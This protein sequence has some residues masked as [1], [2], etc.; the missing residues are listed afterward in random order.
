MKETSKYKHGFKVPDHYFDQL[1]KTIFDRLQE[2]G[3]PKST[4][5]IAPEG[6]FDRLGEEI[7]TSLKM[8]NK[9]KVI[10]LYRKRTFQW[11]AAIAACLLV[12]F[13]VTNNTTTQ[14]QLEMTE[15]LYYLENGGSGISTL[16]IAQY[17]TEEDLSELNVNQNNFSEENLDAYLLE[18]LDD[19]TLL[20]E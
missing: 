19:T 6:Y 5:F 14:N 16:D 17:L 1:E 7:T 18:N 2:E 12:A 15:V 20:T 8:E 13:L 11:A 4:G 3:F 10:P 9:S